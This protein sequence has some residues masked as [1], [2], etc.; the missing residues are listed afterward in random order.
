MK[1]NDIV[2]RKAINNLS[3]ALLSQGK[4]SE[5]WRSFCIFLIHLDKPMPP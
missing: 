4:L 2:E 3:V 5:V 1:A